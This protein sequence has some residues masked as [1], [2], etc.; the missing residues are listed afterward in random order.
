MNEGN[1]QSRTI[2]TTPTSMCL[3]GVG[4]GGVNRA[5]GVKSKEGWK[6]GRKEWCREGGKEKEGRKETVEG[7]E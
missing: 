7:R 3:A 6:E 1:S 4:R 5:H 2:H